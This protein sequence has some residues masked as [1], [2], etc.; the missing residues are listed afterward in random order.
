[1]SDYTFSNWKKWINKNSF[2]NINY[3]GVYCIALSNDNIENKQFSWLEDIIY[4]GM[5]N[6]IGGLKSRLNQFDNT[7]KGKKGHG[8]A[9]RVKFKYNN[10]EKLIIKLLKSIAI[11]L[12]ERKSIFDAFFLYY[13]ACILE[14]DVFFNPIKRSLM[15]QFMPFYD[16]SLKHFRLFAPAYLNLMRKYEAELID[17]NSK[18]EMLG[19]RIKKK[20]V[21][22]PKKKKPKKDEKKKSKK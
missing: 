21:K 13:F 10:Y 2:D 8:G 11:I 22:P 20:K 9:K 7:I 1:M 3:P 6:S 5:T 19:L 18:I 16:F 4:I 12:E 14:Q 15:F 17:L